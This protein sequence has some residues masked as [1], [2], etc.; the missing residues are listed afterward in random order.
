MTEIEPQHI[1]KDKDYIWYKGEKYQKVKSPETLYDV[2]ADW[3]D[4]V[5]TEQASINDLLDRIEKW[6]PSPQSAAGSQNAYVECSVE[7]WNDCLN[8]IKGKLK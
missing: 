1:I 7:G 5:F 3:W 8:K 4:E 6:L 2:I